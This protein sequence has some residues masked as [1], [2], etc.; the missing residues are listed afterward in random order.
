[1][2]SNV[3][4]SIR[5]SDTNEHYLGTVSKPPPHGSRLCLEGQA[6]VRRK[7]CEEGGM[8]AEAQEVV[9]KLHESFNIVTVQRDTV[10]SGRKLRV[11][12]QSEASDR[13]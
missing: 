2:E 5:T 6:A 10:S 7:A 9:T 3:L 13:P 8:C 11:S 4:G 1:M 12:S